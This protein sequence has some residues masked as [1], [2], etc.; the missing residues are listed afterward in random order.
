MSRTT[1]FG[2][3]AGETYGPPLTIRYVT[4]DGERHYY[5]TQPHGV[6]Y[7]M[8]EMRRTDGGTGD[9]WYEAGR[10]WHVRTLLEA[11]DSLADAYEPRVMNIRTSPERER[12]VHGPGRPAIGDAVNLRLGDDLLSEV[13]EYAERTGISRAQ[14]VRYLIGLGLANNDECAYR[15]AHDSTEGDQDR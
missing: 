2:A 6:G 8:S 3:T 9:S 12:I 15:S 11:R 13:G 1:A 14:A 7:H 5:S 4:V 10:S